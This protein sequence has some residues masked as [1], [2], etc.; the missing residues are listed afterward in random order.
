[1]RHVSLL[2]LSAI[3]LQ[4]A[5]AGHLATPPPPGGLLGPPAPDRAVIERGS[6]ATSDEAGSRDPDGDVLV[7]EERLRDGALGCFRR[8]GL[9]AERVGVEADCPGCGPVWRVAFQRLDDPGEIGLCTDPKTPRDGEI[10]LLAW[11][12]EEASIYRGWSEDAPWVWWYSG[13]KHGGR[14]SFHWSA[15]PDRSPGWGHATARR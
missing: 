2:A 14:V 1:M 11:S 5:C 8:F 4:A 12:A 10:R 7:V 15:A 3:L 9:E 6:L 13:V